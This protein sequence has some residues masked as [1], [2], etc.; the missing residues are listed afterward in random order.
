VGIGETPDP[1]PRVIRIRCLVGPWADGGPAPRV[2]R[3]D[4][5]NSP[6][7]LRTARTTSPLADRS[8]PLTGRPGPSDAKGWVGG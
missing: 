4:Q 7:H 5:R 6:N 2:V 3:F 8:Q 1:G